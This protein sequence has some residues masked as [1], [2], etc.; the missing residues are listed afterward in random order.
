M[1]T[2]S[3]NKTLH[4]SEVAEVFR[5]SGIK[6]PYEDLGRI[7]RMIDN[8]DITISAWDDNKLIGIA[9][10]LTDY[11]YC[12]YLSDLAVDQKYQH[13]GIGKALVRKLQAVLG[14]ETSLVLLSAP[15]AV[16]FYPRIG[17]EK[18]ERAFVIAR[19]K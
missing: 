2:Y 10:A 8:A 6:R 15:G 1:I 5:T 7:Q 3:E 9:R 14:D 16:D 18:S 11:S 13:Q 19:K 12:C 4:A 17:F